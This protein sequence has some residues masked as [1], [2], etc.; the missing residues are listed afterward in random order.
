[1]NNF[2]TFIFLLFCLP[3]SLF[4]QTPDTTFVQ[5]FTYADPSPV[6]FSAPYRGTF[7]FPDTSEQYEKVLMYYT[8]KCDAATNQDG[9]P[10][11]EW[12]YLTYTY[13]V[14]STAWYDSTFRTS[15]NYQ[16]SGSTPDSFALSFGPAYEI[17]HDWQYAQVPTD[18]SSISLHPIGSGLSIN[19][20]AI[21]GQFERSRSQFLWRASELIAAGMSVGDITGIRLDL[22]SLGSELRR[23]QIRMKHSNQDSLIAN[24]AEQTGF[25]MAYRLNTAFTQTGIQSLL[26]TQPFS[27]DGSSNIVVEF[28]YDNLNT[29]SNLQVYAESTSWSSGVITTGNEHFLSFEGPDY[30]ELDAS[31]LGPQIQNEITISFWQYGDPAIQPQSDFVFEAKNSSNQRILGSHLPWGNS[32]VYWDAGNEGAGYN[33]INKTANTSEFEGQWNHWAYVKNANTGLMQIFV[34]GQLWHSGGA[35][36]FSMA[37]ITSFVIGANASNHT[38]NYDGYI[39][40][41]RIWSK[42]LDQQTIQDWMHRDL[43]SAHPDYAHLLAY[44]PFNDGDGITPM[45]ASPNQVSADLYGFPDW[46]SPQPTEMNRNWAATQLRPNIIFDQSV[47]IGSLDSTLYIDSLTLSPTSVVI[48][49]NDGNDRL[50]FEGASDHPTLPTDTLMVWQTNGYDYIY[51]AAGVLIDSTVHSAD[52]VIYRNDHQ[53][54]SNVVWYEIGRYITPYGINLDLGPEGTQWVFDVTDYAPLLHDQV[55][56]QAGNNQE[57]LD[58]QFVMVKGEPTRPVRKIENLWRGSW[59]YASLFNN[60]NA[61]AVHKQ[62]DPDGSSFKLKMRISGHGFGGTNTNN[63]AEFCARDHYLYL[64]GTQAFDWEVWKECGDNFVYPQGGT[65]VYDRS[66][67]CPGDI[68]DTYEFDLEGWAGPGDSLEIDYQVEDPAPYTPGGNYVLV[69]QLVTYGPPSHAVDVSIEEILAPNKEKR[70]SRRNPICD[71]PRIRIKNNGTT[72]LSKL[73]FSYGVEGGFAN[74]YYVWEGELGFLESADIDLPRF[75]WTGLD[76]N[77]PVFFVEVETPT[78]MDENL[79]NNRL[80]V[81]FE[82]PRQIFSGMILNVRTNSAAAENS[83]FV[84]DAYGHAIISRTNLQSNTDYYDTL[85]L[86]EG[87]YTFHLKDEDF[88]PG[89]GNDGLAWW[90]NNDGTGYAHLLSWN[91]AFDSEW[92]PDFGSEIYEQFTV[93]YRIGDTFF[94]DLLCDS[95]PKDTATAI[96]SLAIPPEGSITL[97]PNPTSGQFNLQV[98]LDQ[99]E[100]LDIRIFNSLGMMVYEG[101]R[102][103]IRQENIQVNP[104]LSPGVYMVQ[105]KTS[106][107]QFSQSLIVR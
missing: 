45:D 59:S 18:T 20:Q 76:P 79:N 54:Y 103:G 70:F 48:Y 55:Y 66:G 52:S 34:N 39:D 68:V 3:V 86:P 10:C 58:L 61:Q 44:Y 32:Q 6:G 73:H 98:E 80:A 35:K 22:A 95:L 30:V 78:L 37:G 7:S 46:K 65:W 101:N 107:H 19:D 105:I 36:T 47:Y 4:S 14:D 72:P 97:F 5:T 53:Y 57:L 82:R 12:D 81:P 26:F 71:H 42:A 29:G 27:W 21:G 17:T 93:A 96:H 94:P 56:I 89:S 16:I 13:I 28:S 77:D 64:N 74:C 67:W 83:Y 91:G 24:S 15:A 100:N 2:Y 102:V 50:F 60:T 104:Q 8:L 99:R 1:M 69:G 49:G 85:N 75:N 90:A 92:E 31:L 23:F 43:T 63:C 40:D 84:Y 38:R 33:R 87:C 106:R 88:F 9:F 11:G 41:F 51:D 62:L 25:Q